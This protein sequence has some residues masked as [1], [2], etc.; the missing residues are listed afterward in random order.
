MTFLTDSIMSQ[1]LISI[2]ENQKVEMAETLMRVNSIRHLPVVDELNELSGI[3]SATDVANAHDKKISVKSVMS[4][5]VRIIKQNS[6]IKKIIEQMLRFKISSMLVASGDELVGIVTT[7]DLLQLLYEL[8]DED[9]HVQ[10][11]EVPNLI[12][13]DWIDGDDE[14]VLQQVGYST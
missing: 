10:A 2:E 5:R 1:N 9:E 12:E 14:H 4:P 7:D 11:S 3:I 8:L 13:N 6:N